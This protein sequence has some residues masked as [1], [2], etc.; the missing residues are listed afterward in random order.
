MLTRYFKT[1]LV[2]IFAALISFSAPQ[3]FA[4]ENSKTIK[5]ETPT[6]Q[7]GMCKNRIEKN[8]KD[9]TGII[10]S[11]VDYKEKHTTVTY[12]PDKISPKEIR[13]AIADIGYK[14]GDVEAD[15]K[16]YKNLPACCKMSED[17]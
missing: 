9:I 13:K 8:L 2:A 14:A 12:N 11:D 7:C 6:V 16:A 5:I 3:L 10:S 4:G 15:K 17:R 1:T